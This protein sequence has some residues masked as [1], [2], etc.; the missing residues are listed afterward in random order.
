[1]KGEYAYLLL[2]AFHMLFSIIIKVCCNYFPLLMGL[3]TS[4]IK[5]SHVIFTCSICVKEYE[6]RKGE[7]LKRMKISFAFFDNFFFAAC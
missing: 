6:K 1:M 4:D 3:K 5:Y 2:L 7:N